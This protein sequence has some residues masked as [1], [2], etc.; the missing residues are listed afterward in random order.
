MN[1]DSLVLQELRRLF[2]VDEFLPVE[3]LME[4]ALYHPQGGLYRRTCPAQGR[5]GQF[6]TCA[7]IDAGLGRA[8]A[9]WI[10]EVTSP[11]E[12]GDGISEVIEVGG[13][14]GALARAVIESL[15]EAGQAHRLHLVELSE[16]AISLQREALAQMDCHWHDSIQEA[17]RACRG[18]ALIYSNELVDAFPATVVEFR[19]GDWVEV[20]LRLEDERLRERVAARS[21]PSEE[22][23]RPAIFELDAPREGCRGEIHFSYRRWL[24]RWVPDLHRGAMLTI[25]YGGSSAAVYSRTSYGTLRAYF[26]NLRLEEREDLYNRLGR[27]DLTCDVNFTDLRRW[28]EA[29][30]LETQAFMTQRE[31]LDRYGVLEDEG[32]D[33]SLAFIARPGGAGTSF[34]ALWQ[35]RISKP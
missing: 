13:G 19:G 9:G 33:S 35:K 2:E 22:G 12:D 7:R 15:S 5:E 18:E 20:G 17:V 11:G 1:G 28:G 32:A 4:V 26:A 34:R 3:K 23:A 30:G 8:V 21:W 14:D 27:Q 10:R 24:E 6:T 31:L 16:P 25:D 29:L